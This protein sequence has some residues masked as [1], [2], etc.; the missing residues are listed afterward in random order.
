MTKDEL[1]ALLR[2]LDR[3]GMIESL[4]KASLRSLE[5]RGMIES[6][7]DTDGEVYWRCTAKG[8][9]VGDGEADRPAD[10]PY[11]LDS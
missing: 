11:G 6:F 10:S 4:V 7:I 3:K 5:R 1:K 9:A 2:S 8:I